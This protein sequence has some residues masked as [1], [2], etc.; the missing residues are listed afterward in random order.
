MNRIFQIIFVGLIFLLTSC[1]GKIDPVVDSQ[2]KAEERMKAALRDPDSA[3]YSNVQAFRMSGNGPVSY[4]FC[5]EV[6]AKNGFGGYTGNTGF[7]AGPALATLE[8]TEQGDDAAA[9]ELIWRNLCSQT[10]YVEDVGFD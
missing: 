5:G 2:G 8:T 6:N 9:F 4:V 7:V 1:D 3:K 10:N